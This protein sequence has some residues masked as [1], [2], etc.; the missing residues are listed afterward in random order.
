MTDTPERMATERDRM[1]VVQ[2][3]SAARRREEIEATD[4]LER[5]ERALD[6]TTVP[7]LEALLAGVTEKP[8]LP[9][10]VSRRGLFT[11]L[12]VGAV[13]LAGGVIALNQGPDEPAARATPRVTPTPTPTP[14]PTATPT[15]T[16]AP[17]PVPSLFTVAG[18]ELLLQ[19]YRRKFGTWWTYELTVIDEDQARSD[20]PIGPLRKRRLQWWSWDAD[21]RWNTIFDPSPVG[22]PGARALDLREVN[23]KAALA[24]RPKARRSLGVENPEPPG[25]EITWHREYGAVV[26]YYVSNSFHEGGVMYTDLAGNILARHPFQRS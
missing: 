19:D 5:T 15:P 12:G 26:Q 1:A 14:T 4:Q 9:V 7:E 3:L 10:G 25:L 16:P 2:A 24:N 13:A 17:P 20:V 6:A 11:V 18:L 8:E 23:L 21:D 22:D